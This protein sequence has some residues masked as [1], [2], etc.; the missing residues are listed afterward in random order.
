MPGAPL[1]NPPLINLQANFDIISSCYTSTAR[2]NISRLLSE[3]KPIIF[4]SLFIYLFLKTIHVIVF[5]FIDWV[6]EHDNHVSEI[7]LL[8]K[9]QSGC[10]LY[11]CNRENDLKMKHLMK[12]DFAGFP[13]IWV[14]SQLVF[15]FYEWSIHEFEWPIDGGSILSVR[16]NGSF[17]PNRAINA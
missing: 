3:L 11:L 13:T 7:T 8:K 1:L 10:I 15:Q 6:A 2:Q 17:S 16:L 5:F 12:A 14:R 4:I 9:F